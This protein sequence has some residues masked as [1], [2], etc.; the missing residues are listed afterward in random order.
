MKP[1]PNDLIELPDLARELAEHTGEPPEKYRALYN[2]TVDG[3]LPAEKKNGRWRFRRRHLPEIA[4]LLS[5]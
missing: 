3:V 1:D 5:A 4:K 2:M